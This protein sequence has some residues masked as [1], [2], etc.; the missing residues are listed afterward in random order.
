MSVAWRDDSLPVDDKKKIDSICLRFEGDWLAGRRPLLEPYL[1]QLHAGAQA[2]LFRELLLLELDYRRALREEPCADDYV[3][4]FPR[5][6]AVI[7]TVFESALSRPAPARFVPGSMIGRYE[8]RRMLGTG[9]FAVVYLAWD[10]QLNREVAIK[11]PHRFLLSSPAA[12]QRFLDEARTVAGLRHPG[13]VTL[14]DVATLPEDG[15]VYLVMQYVAGDSLRQRLQ[16]GPLPPQQAG[17]I[18]AGV[19]DAMAAA[20]R[21]GV[22]H[23][24]LKPKNILLDE[25]DGPHVCDFGLAVNVDTQRERK[26]EQ[27]GTLAYMAPEQIRGESHQLDGR[28]DIWALGVIHYEM[29]TGKVPFS[30]RNRDELCNDILQRDP[31]PPR[32]VD[33]RIPRQ[34]ERIC[35]ECLGKQ[36]NQRPTTAGDVSA[37]LRTLHREKRRG[38]LVSLLLLLLVPS[39]LWIVL[40]AAAFRLPSLFGDRSLPVPLNA[41]MD[42]LV[43]DPDNSARQG[44]SATSAHALPLC[45]GDQVR[46]C[47][48]LN[49]PA[50]V[51][52][53]WLNADGSVLPVHP[54]RGGDWSSRPGKEFPRLYLTLPEKLDHGW[55]MQVDTDGLESV[56][57][58]ARRSPLPRDVNLRELLEGGAQALPA[59][60]STATWFQDGMPLPVNQQP[61]AATLRP[62]DL[63]NLAGIQA[64]LLK[65]Q[66]HLADILRPHFELIRAV[67]FPVNK[68][69]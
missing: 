40:A 35:L 41:R 30:G 53:L 17:R 43:W 14:F 38:G 62:P 10:A 63:G 8:V 52:L 64:P 6:G 12:R 48:Q 7:R 45:Q 2:A 46:L 33:T 57:L 21:V 9:A 37:A 3:Q 60:T 50:Y 25:N 31:R 47:L 15:T 51:Y 26:G 54:W 24:D 42:L 67:S 44:V 22:F 61:D 4:R 58:L 5:M 36:P 39:A 34:Q 69:R 59:K 55:A 56:L 65:M 66:H 28:A 49:Q 16:S 29:L 11:V 18:A 13:I 1:T 20:H 23:R 32:Q 68:E 19:A 27:A